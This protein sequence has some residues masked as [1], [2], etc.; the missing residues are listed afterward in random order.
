MS[1]KHAKTAT[2]GTPADPTK[3]GGDD[4]NADHVVDQD[5]ITMTARTDVPAA[6]ASGKANIFARTLAGRVLPAVVGSEGLSSILQPHIGRN[7]IAYWLPTGNSTTITTL[8][9]PTPNASGTSR[10]VATTNFFQSL[11]RIGYTTAATANANTNIRTNTPQF[12]LGSSAGMGGFHYVCRFGTSNASAVTDGRVFM[13]FSTTSG[14]LGAVN[15]STLLNIL[16]IGYDGG[17]TNWA[18]FNNDGSGSATKTDLGVNFPCTTQSVDVYELSMFAPP[19]S[20]TVKW[21]VTRLNTG[22]FASGTFSSDIPA[23]N[24]L[25]QPHFNVSSGASASS[26]GLDVMSLYIETDS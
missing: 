25:L 24:T 7:K 19:N 2:A 5:G 22:D 26:V 3:V 15:S 8:G 18:M 16:G 23:I 6:T 13:G 21:A 17:D 20:T 11:R 14:S 10:N 1:L 12:F 9:M 4:W